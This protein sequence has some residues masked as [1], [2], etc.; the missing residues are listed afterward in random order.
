MSDEGRM[1]VMK[2][3][4]KNRTAALVEGLHLCRGERNWKKHRRVLKG[5]KNVVLSCK[6]AAR[7]VRQKVVIESKTLA[8][9]VT[10]DEKFVGTT[11]IPLVGPCPEK[12]LDQVRRP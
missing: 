8:T 4:S 10:L 6:A 11:W 9:T 5:T 3:D 2:E 12:S 1:R 7:L